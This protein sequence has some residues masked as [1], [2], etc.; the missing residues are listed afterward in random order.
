MFVG[1]DS[2]DDNGVASS[3]VYIFERNET[4]GN[5]NQTFKL[6]ANDGADNDHFGSS[7]GVFENILVVGAVSAYYCDYNYHRGFAYV[8]ERDEIS[9]IWK[10][11][12]KLSSS[13]SGSRW[14]FLEQ[15]LVFLAMLWLL[16][17]IGI[18]MIIM[19]M[20]ISM[21][22]AKPVENENKKTSFIL[23]IHSRL[24]ILDT[25][26]LFLEMFWLLVQF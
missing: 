21:R 14:D 17:Q 9:G 26:L 6:V 10:Q 23:M 4:S 13:L 2:D 8:F 15:V 19:V 18:L 16:V 20:L 7:V 3:S 25:V 1:A 24:T 5:W 12:A 11:T 22:G